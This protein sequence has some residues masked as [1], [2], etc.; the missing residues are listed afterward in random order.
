MLTVLRRGLVL[1]VLGCVLLVPPLKTEEGTHGNLVDVHWLE[2]HSSR[3]DVLILDVSPAAAY[4]ASHI[5]GA[6]SA[7]FFAYGISETSLSEMT[8]RFQSWGISP[9]KSIVVYDQ[10]GSMMATRLF[11]SLYYSGFPVQ[12]LFVLD[13]GLFKW[14]KEGLPVTSE[15]I[16]APGAGSFHVVKFDGAAKAELPE[17]LTASG[18]PV[19]NV[20]L[21]A[22]GPDWHYGEVHPFGRAG[23]IPRGILLPSA[24]FYNP[25][26]TFK[27]PEEL[28]RMLRY[29]GIG[30]EQQIFTYCGGGV[31]AS[32]PY[33]ALKFI[34]NYPSVKLYTGSEMEWLNDEREL[35]YW[36]YDAPYLMRESGWLEF[37]TG[38][39][40]RALGLA[41]VSIVDVRPAEAFSQG[42]IPFA[43]NVPMEVFRAN[44]A[45]PGKL[46]LAL[47]GVNP[48]DEAVVVSGNALTKESALAFAMLEQIGQTKVSVLTDFE[49]WTQPGL[50]LT[51]EVIAGRADVAYSA[52]GTK[53][54]LITDPNS[55]HGVYPKV[56][57]ASGKEMPARV[58]DGKVIHLPYTDLLN[59]ANKPKPAKDVWN[60]LNRAGVPRYAELVCV[61]DDPGEAAVT[62][63]ILK[64]M[65]YPDIK[66]L[67]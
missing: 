28:T 61:S 25:D 48:S 67:L 46:A 50:S 31:A 3:P 7:D 6:V 24:D 42:H 47:A 40:P 35:P 14:Q 65:G 8:K 17:F 36:T 34:L 1:V 33:F 51:K 11:F 45:N 27:S 37:W 22:L 18:D 38:Q 41:H 39:M 20:L 12:N 60:V 56:F 13:G 30:P 55:T 43:V 21:E 19:H 9:G 10:G 2:K 5:P 23:H 49:K 26:R 57:L 32:V 58:P 52:N 54:V 44:L 16:A 66:V 59:S 15:A 29:F 53:S 63:F 64:L 62:Y 4:K